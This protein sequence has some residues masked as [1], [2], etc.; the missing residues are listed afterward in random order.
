DYYCQTW[1]TGIHVL[2]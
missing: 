2:F 1:T